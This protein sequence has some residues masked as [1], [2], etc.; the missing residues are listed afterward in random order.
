MTLSQSEALINDLNGGTFKKGDIVILDR[1]R[2]VRKY[3]VLRNGRLK[4][5]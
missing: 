3:E 2:G 4:L 5:K 1:G